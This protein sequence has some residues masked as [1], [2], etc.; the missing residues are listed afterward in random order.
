MNIPPRR[1]LLSALVDDRDDKLLALPL[2]ATTATSLEPREIDTEGDEDLYKDF[3]A[4][5]GSKTPD[6]DAHSSL[7]ELEYMHTSDVEIV[8]INQSDVQE[9]PR[10]SSVR[11]S[12][13]LSI[14][15]DVF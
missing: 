14:L 7:D 6:L 13:V 11:V 12:I 8:A 2:T 15:F 1:P 4:V 10:K 9:I 5:Q 3:E